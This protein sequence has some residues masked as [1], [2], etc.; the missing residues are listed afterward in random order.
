M[1]FSTN[2]VKFITVNINERSLLIRYKIERSYQMNQ[3]KLIVNLFDMAN[4]LVHLGEPNLNS[5][6]FELEMEITERGVTRTIPLPIS[7]RVLLATPSDLIRFE[8]MSNNIW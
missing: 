3:F 7:E 4:L 5:I 2:T 6:N 8:L 1:E